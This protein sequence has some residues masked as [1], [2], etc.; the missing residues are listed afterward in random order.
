MSGAEEQSAFASPE[1]RVL[2]I[3]SAFPPTGGPGV[4]RSVKFAKYLPH[5]GWRPTVW[6]VEAAEDLPRDETLS[7]DLPNEVSVVRWGSGSHLRALRRL[8]HAH[9]DGSGVVPRLAKAVD[10]RLGDWLTRGPLPDECAEWARASAQPACRLVE[11]ERIGVIYSTFSPASNHLLALLLKRKTRLPWV[12]DFRDLWTDDY[13]YRENSDRRRSAHRKLEQEILEAADVVVGV[14]ERQTRI[15]ASR[16]PYEQYKCVTI[17]NG[18]DPADFPERSGEKRPDDNTFL[19]AHVGRFDRWR[20]PKVWFA[21]LERFVETLGTDRRRFAL[22]IVGHIDDSTR[23][24]LQATGATCTFTGYVSHA[25][26]VQEMRSADGLLLNVPDGPNAESV[27]PAKLFEYLAADQ[28][29]LVVGPVDGEA[30]RIVRS[31]AA[32]VTANFNEIQIADAL[33]RLFAGWYAGRPLYGCDPVL[34]APFR[35][36]TL[37]GELASVFNRLVGGPSGPVESSPRSVGVGV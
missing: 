37:T 22:R 13:R 11:R 32:G 23:S 30:E 1:R 3:A 4:Q 6:T 19:L 5:F 12:A 21:G 20:T 27:I 36:D 2:M 8:V 35:R 34:L 9:A 18:F 10:W 29:I 26:A 28:P 15:L 16:V 14:S 31:C 17:T 24:R 7:V 33:G 25:R